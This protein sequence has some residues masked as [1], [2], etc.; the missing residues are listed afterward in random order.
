MKQGR[1]DEVDRLGVAT[2]NRWGNCRAR[3]RTFCWLAT[4]ARN[5]NSTAFGIPVLPE[6]NRTTAGSSSLF[7][8]GMAGGS[9]LPWRKQVCSIAM[10]TNVAPGGPDRERR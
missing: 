7:G 8:P 1:G 2:G 4:T 9:E 10:S 3:A 6:V 5:G